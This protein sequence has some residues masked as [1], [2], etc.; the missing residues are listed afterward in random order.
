MHKW[1]ACPRVCEL[2]SASRYALLGI[3][4]TIVTVI[5]FLCNRRFLVSYTQ[6]STGLMQ[7]RSGQVY[8]Y[9]TQEFCALK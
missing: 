2:Q 9:F 7:M 3:S 1:S 8:P 4:T 6:F 5:A